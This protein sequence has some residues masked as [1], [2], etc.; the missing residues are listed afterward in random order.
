[1]RLLSKIYNRCTDPFYTLDLGENKILT[2][3]FTNRLFNPL[4]ALL[5]VGISCCAERPVMSC[6]QGANDFVL[7]YIADSFLVSFGCPGSG[8]QLGPIDLFIIRY[9]P[10]AMGEIELTYNIPLL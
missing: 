3:K 2:A 6:D 9:N 5:S 10:A 7:P 4:L 1:M 8:V